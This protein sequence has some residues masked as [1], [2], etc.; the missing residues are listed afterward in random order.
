[1]TFPFGYL[2][3]PDEGSATEKLLEPNIRL[4]NLSSA[5]IKNNTTLFSLISI[6]ILGQAEKY[7]LK[8]QE[9]LL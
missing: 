2:L 3:G 6:G 8:M 9:S 7:I 1:M 4:F 5:F